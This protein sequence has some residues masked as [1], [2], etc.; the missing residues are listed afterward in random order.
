MPANTAYELTLIIELLVFGKI[1]QG[2]SKN[3][4]TVY[5]CRPICAFWHSLGLQVS[6]RILHYMRL[7]RLLVTSSLFLSRS[8]QM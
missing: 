8:L 2:N 3:R 4:H 5:S 6:P 1:E 7:T